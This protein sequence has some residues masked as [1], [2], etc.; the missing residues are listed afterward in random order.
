LERFLAY[1]LEELPFVI[2]S[3]IVAFTFHELAHA[4]VAYRFGDL[5]A[6]KQGRLTLNP[7][8]HLDPFGTI[9]ILIAGFGWARPVPV[10]RSNFKNPRLAGVL[11]SIAGPLANFLIAFV[12]YA[13]FYFISISGFG[14]NVPLFVTRLLDMMVWLNLLLFVFNLIPLPPLDGYR[15][16]EDLVNPRTRAKL[17]QYEHYGTILF[18]IV[19]ITP[20]SQYTIS[21]IFSTV[22]PAILGSF[23]SIFSSI[24]G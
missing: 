1:P 18:L 5:T 19:A 17:T 6:Q 10:N 15:I 9:L 20:I 3:L 8:Q 16:I 13:I 12:A 11:V 7:I 22:L 2:I 14:E 24:F 23:Q 4:Y 21:P